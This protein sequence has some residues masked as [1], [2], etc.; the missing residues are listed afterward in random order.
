[1]DIAKRTTADTAEDGP[2]AG[3]S[4]AFFG[5]EEYPAFF[6]AFMTSFDSLS[7]IPRE[8][9]VMEFNWLS[10]AGVL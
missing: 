7:S 5:D 2:D 8:F 3:S 6:M 10:F 4:F 1:M 9:R